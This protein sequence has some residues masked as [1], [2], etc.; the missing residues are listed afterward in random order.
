MRTSYKLISAMFAV[1]L[2]A[3]P[4]SAQEPNA[5]PSSGSFKTNGIFK[6]NGENAEVAKDHVVA[7]GLIWGG[8]YNDAGSGPLHAGFGVCTAAI[9]IVKGAATGE[10]QC[11]FSDTDGK[12]QIFTSWTGKA[13]PGGQFSGVHEITGG[14]GRYTGIEGRAPV[15]C[16]N[17][18][19]KGQFACIYEWQY[20]I[21]K[22]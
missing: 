2:L 16:L 11:G 17:S 5:L 7:S 8:T 21:A 4:A 12:S 19:D 20:R 13:P 3:A 14:T 22:P 18:N 15:H 9:E 1:A 6:F 10:G